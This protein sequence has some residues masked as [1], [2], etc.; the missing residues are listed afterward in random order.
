MNCLNSLHFLE[1]FNYENIVLIPKKSVPEGVVDLRLIALC[2]I[3]YKLVAKMI[4][5]RMKDLSEAVDVGHYLH[6]KQIRHVGRAG[7]KL[8]MANAYDR[9]E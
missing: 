9:M 1:D 7:L 6:R 8:D 4:S 5:N 2:N 3:L